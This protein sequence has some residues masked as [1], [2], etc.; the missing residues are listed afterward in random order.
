MDKE[1]LKVRY[2]YDEKSGK[3]ITVLEK[4]FNTKTEGSWIPIW[5]YKKKSGIVNVW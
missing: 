3:A 1:L 4:L 2:R 5:I